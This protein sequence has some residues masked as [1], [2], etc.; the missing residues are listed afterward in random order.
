MYSNSKRVD[1]FDGGPLPLNT[2]VGLKFTVTT[3]P[4]TSDVK[5]ELWL[6][7]NDEGNWELGYEYLDTPDTWMA[8]TD[9]SIN[10]IVPTECN[11]E[12]GDTVVRPGRVSFLRTDGLADQLTTE[13]HWRNVTINNNAAVTTTTTQATTTT[14]APP[15]YCYDGIE[16]SASGFLV[17]CANTECNGQCGGTGCSTRPGGAAL[18]CTGSIISNEIYCEDASD[19][20]CIIPPATTT[21]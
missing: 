9:P 3:M 5:L 21:R 14:E 19:V 2:W 20:G 11:H 12:D 6:D 16:K 7:R 13:V 10:K 18:C 8:N 4:G 17:C 1:C 15:E